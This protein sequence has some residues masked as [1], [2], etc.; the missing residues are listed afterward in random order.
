MEYYLLMAAAGAILAAWA[1]RGF[2]REQG[3]RAILERIHRTWY[4][5]GN[6]RD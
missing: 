4:Y 2:R 1:I 3:R 6:P 5:P